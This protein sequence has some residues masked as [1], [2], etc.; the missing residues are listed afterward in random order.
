MSN[1]I[2]VCILD[3]RDKTLQ[4]LDDDG[5]NVVHRHAD[6]QP[7]TWQLVGDAAEGKFLSP[8][9]TPAGIEWLEPKAPTGT[10]KVGKLSHA[11]K[12]LKVD[13]T[14]DKAST[15]GEWRYKL[16]VRIGTDIYE[17]IS[18]LPPVVAVSDPVIINR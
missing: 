6:G 7:I 10:F 15:A 4:T 17:T 12:V 3:A 9:G 5:R 11:D 8:T 18:T 1:I 13:D 16:R 2:G 14:N